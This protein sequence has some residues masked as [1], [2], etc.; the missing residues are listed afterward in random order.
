MTRRP[1]DSVALR[2]SCVSLDAFLCSEMPGQ[3]PQS[4]II[5][6]TLAGECRPARD[7]VSYYP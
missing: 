3:I 7:I 4:R 6:E 5:R 2:F 1:E